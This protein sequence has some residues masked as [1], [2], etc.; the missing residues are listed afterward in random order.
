M[1]E[2]NQKIG[3]AVLV[4]CILL[5]FAVCFKVMN[6]RF[7]RLSRYPYEDPAKRALID[8]YLND[9]EIE[10]IIEYAIAP[11]YFIDYIEVPGFNIYHVEEYRWLKGERDYLSY[12]EVV[13]F[14]EL[15]YSREGGIE[16]AHD[17]LYRGYSVDTAR[18]WFTNGDRYISNS[19]LVADPTAYDAEVNET[20]GVLT[21]E[22]YDL[23]AV[24]DLWLRKDAASA[25]NT[26][27]TALEAEL[28]IEVV[29]VRAY[30]SYEELEAAYNAGSK[31]I[32]GH[33]DHQLGLSVDLCPEGE[34][35]EERLA[36]WLVRN[37]GKY[38]FRVDKGHLRYTGEVRP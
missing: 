3:R 24:G 29:P 31:E 38:G 25:F 37:A 8:K 5:L 27:K 21:Y 22:P 10:Y 7:D 1:N 9:E 30:V 19:A 2:K 12:E 17:L 11:N 6:N 26:L 20:E 34:A 28:D 33:S 18:D 23:T 32:P 14:I 4:A 13:S 15:C 16:E 35:P 36:Q